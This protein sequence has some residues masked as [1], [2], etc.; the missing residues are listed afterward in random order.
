MR[1][2]IR[3]HASG[4]WVGQEMEL[5]L[6]VAALTTLM[7]FNLNLLVRIMRL[8]RAFSTTPR[9]RADRE[10]GNLASDV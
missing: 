2:G 8:S 9:R 4:I 3:N 10:E 7:N 5:G 6:H 1:V